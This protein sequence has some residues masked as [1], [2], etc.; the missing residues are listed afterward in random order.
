MRPLWTAPCIVI[1][2]KELTE[3]LREKR[4]L[5]MLAMLTLLYP[6]LVGL[7]LH[8]TIER[9]TRSAKAGIELAVIGAA[10]APNLLARLR[11]NGVHVSEHGPMS[12]AAIQSL[13][14]DKKLAGVLRLPADFAGHYAEL[15][16][17][18]IHI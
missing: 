18:L 17:S 1:M 16:L 11:Q 7:L 10:Q 14:R 4:T 5:G 12:E 15:R 13:L 2:L 3:A 6:A 9:G 8:T